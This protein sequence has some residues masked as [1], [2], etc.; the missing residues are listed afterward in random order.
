MPHDHYLRLGHALGEHLGCLVPGRLQHQLRHLEVLLGLGRLDRRVL[1]G[2]ADVLSDL[3]PDASQLLL[4][5]LRTGL[6]LLA[7]ASAVADGSAPFVQT[8]LPAD[9]DG[10]TSLVENRLALGVQLG[11]CALEDDTA[12]FGDDFLLVQI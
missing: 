7:N 2:L 10:L 3:N 6:Q 5:V 9:Q 8:G 4:A 1:F 12:D 11:L